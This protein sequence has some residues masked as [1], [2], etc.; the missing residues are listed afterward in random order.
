MDVSLSVSHYWQDGTV[1]GGVKHRSQHH[2]PQT[3]GRGNCGKAKSD[4]GWWHATKDAIWDWDIRSGRI[5]RSETFWEHLGYPPKDPEPDMAAGKTCFTPK[6]GIVCGTDSRL[7][8]YGGLILMKSSIAF[9]G[10]M[11]PTQ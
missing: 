6:T 11:T 2:Q 7:H 9:D 1:I 8:C 5:W 10:R 3:N 4:S